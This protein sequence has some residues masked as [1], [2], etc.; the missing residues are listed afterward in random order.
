MV[1]GV[2]MYGRGAI[3]RMVQMARAGLIDLA[4]FE[5][6]RFGLDEANQAVAYA[7]ANAGPHQLT[8]LRPD[9]AGH[10]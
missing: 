6:A 3:S 9:R 2:W 10:N 7:A 8:V 4:Q 5:L 1:R